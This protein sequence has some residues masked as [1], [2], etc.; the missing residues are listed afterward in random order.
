M[1]KEKRFHWLPVTEID[2]NRSCSILLSLVRL[3]LAFPKGNISSKLQTKQE[4]Y[5]ELLVSASLN[6]FLGPGSSFVK[7]GLI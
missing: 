2:C 6:L 4:A 7:Q 5:F 3:N 1:P